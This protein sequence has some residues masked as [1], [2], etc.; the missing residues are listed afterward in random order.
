MQESFKT[1]LNKF[2][3][4]AGVLLG[5]LMLCS[6]ALYNGYPLIYPDTGT[7]IA[8]CFDHFIPRDRP[9]T[10]SFFIRHISLSA[11]LW[12]PI[13]VQCI[14]VSWIIFLLFRHLARV[15]KVFWWQIGTIAVLTVTTGIAANTGQLIADVFTS[16]A[17]IGSALLLFSESLNRV[18]KF[19]LWALVV[20]S[21]TTHLSHYPML[22]ALLGTVLL[23]WFFIRKKHAHIIRLKPLI[24]LS[25]V[26]PAAIALTMTLNYIVA[27]EVRFSPGVSHVFMMNRLI[28]TGILDQYLDANCGRRPSTLC[29]YRAYLYGDFLWDENSALN[30][31]YKWDENGWAKAKPEY[32]SIISE[33]FDNPDYVKQYIVADLRDAAKQLVT[34][35]VVEMRVQLQ[36][37]APYEN[38]KAH[39]LEE[40]NSYITAKQA[41]GKLKY[42][43]LNSI[44]VIVIS[45]FSGILILI[46]ALPVFRRMLSWQL[47][48][49][50]VWILFAM[51]FNALTVVSVAMIDGRYQARLIWLIPLSVALI[52][53]H[54]TE[55]H[56][57]R[58]LLRKQP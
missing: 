13:I 4:A 23:V 12:L 43:T 58:T 30:R 44:Q 53:A 27:Q 45:I 49:L 46:F 31:H 17:I 57:W 26:I 14:I 32:D 48:S 5:A 6:H 15:K 41:S 42:D 22:C 8:A 25:S 1:Q 33:V 35:R 54:I 2:R 28:Q 19:A 40:L 9:L 3:A 50:N 56:G 37:T 38:I 10:Y 29:T 47:I 16:I 34:F 18:T 52:L 21:I 36:G 39:F 20:F 51:I 24:I 11:T 55:K 7:Y